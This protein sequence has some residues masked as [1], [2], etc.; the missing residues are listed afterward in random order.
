MIITAIAFFSLAAIIG[1][2]LLSFVLKGKKPSRAL[3]FTHGPLALTGIILLIAY[4][5]NHKPSPTDALILFIIAATGGIIL[6][7]RDLMGKTIPKWLGVLHG[8]IA[9]VGFVCLL[10]F[11]FG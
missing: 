1:M 3:V 11:Q 8:L 4:S 2:V 6:V 9:V 7:A 5:A 10:I